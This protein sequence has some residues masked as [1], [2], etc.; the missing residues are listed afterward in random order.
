MKKPISTL[1]I[2]LIAAFVFGQNGKFYASLDDF[3]NDKPASGVEV[4]NGSWQM[5]LGSESIKV[6]SG[7]KTDRQKISNLPYDFFTYDNGLMMRN[8]GKMYMVLVTGP[9]CLYTLFTRQA[10]LHYSE[11]IK[12]EVMSFNEGK[13]KKYL[14]QYG[15]LEAFK[16][17]KPKR[18]M[19]D[20][21]DD[22]FNKQV[23]WYIKY[24]KLLNQKMK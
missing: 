5:L 2:V 14:E 1:F 11:T 3:K 19:R 18:E 4:V 7:G 10:D 8:G 21:V 9:F 24:I 17:D 20:N 23:D 12:G 6:V 22:Y 16:K 15:L 13:L